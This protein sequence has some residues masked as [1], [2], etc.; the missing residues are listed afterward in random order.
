MAE[1]QVIG[2]IDLT[3]PLI[4][5]IMAYVKLEPL[6]VNVLRT[7]LEELAAGNIN[8][9]NAKLPEAA[10]EVD[11]ENWGADQF[12]IIRDVDDEWVLVSPELEADPKDDTQA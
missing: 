11:V 4:D 2:P 3:N 7:M 5:E 10:F 12:Y 1:H 9:Y 6:N 8:D